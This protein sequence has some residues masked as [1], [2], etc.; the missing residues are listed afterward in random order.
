MKRRTRPA[1]S[2]PSCPA[3]VD[4]GLESFF[5]GI[6]SL[7]DVEGFKLLFQVVA[8]APASESDLAHRFLAVF[9]EA[10][11]LSLI[12]SATGFGRFHVYHL[13]RGGDSVASF[14]LEFR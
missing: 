9:V 7:S 14:S 11:S 6:D 12:Q 10:R 5:P 4:S 1:A 8:L 3:P 13:F 2:R